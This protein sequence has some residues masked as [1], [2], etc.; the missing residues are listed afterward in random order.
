MS[1]ILFLFVV[2][3]VVISTSQVTAN[4]YEKE[5]RNSYDYQLSGLLAEYSLDEIKSMLG[6]NNGQLY[7]DFRVQSDTEGTVTYQVP[8]DDAELE[9][10]LG[11]SNNNVQNNDFQPMNTIISPDFTW[12]HTIIRDSGL[13]HSESIVI[14]LMG[15]AFT[16]ADYGTWP[17][18]AAGTVLALADAAISTMESTYPFSEFTHLFTVYVV[19]VASETSGTN[20]ALGTVTE[21]GNLVESNDANDTVN[22]NEIRRLAREI[23]ANADLTVL[24]VI[25]NATARTGFG[26][27]ALNDEID[28]NIGVTS[29][30]TATNGGASTHWPRAWHGTIIHEFGHTLGKL[31]DNHNT[32]GGRDNARANI[33]TNGNTNSVKWQHWLGHQN[34]ADVP[35]SIGVSDGTE[36]FVPSIYT[37]RGT[38]L[39]GGN[40]IMVASWAHGEFCGVCAEE[41][42]RRMGSNTG[43]MLGVNAI[44]FNVISRTNGISGFRTYTIR[45]ENNNPFAAEVT[46]IDRQ[47]SESTAR[48]FS[49]NNTVTIMIPANGSQNVSI[50]ESIGTSYIAANIVFVTGPTRFRMISYANELPAALSDNGRLNRKFNVQDQGVGFNAINLTA[51]TAEIT[52]STATLIGEIYIPNRINGRAVTSIGNSAFSGQTR[53][54]TVHLPIPLQTLGNSAFS[55][56]SNLNE[57]HIS[58]SVTTIGS[59]AFSNTNNAPIYL[60]GRS[61]VPSTFDRNWNSSENPVYLNGRLCTHNKKTIIQLDSTQHGHLC[62]DCR[63]ITNKE[64]HRKYTS[65]GW[66]YCYDCSYSKPH[67]HS[68]TPTWINYKLHELKCSCGNVTNLI[69]HVVS[70]GWNGIGYATCLE[71]GGPAEIGIVGPSYKIGKTNQLL[72]IFVLDYFGNGSFILNNGVI[73][74]SDKDLVHYY[75]GTLVIPV[76][77][78]HMDC[79]KHENL[80]IEIVNDNLYYDID[81]TK[82]GFILTSKKQ[83]EIY[84][85]K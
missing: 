62:N 7:R 60:V 26:W 27:S 36:W 69:G 4:A 51:T 8:V 30:R 42:S 48:Y 45:L 34:V 43:W 18:P 54:T 28:I 12:P 84:K 15:D 38:N 55:G 39:T 64:N 61:G 5:A 41:L 80:D 78:S 63:T 47:V 71:C 46:Y 82:Y 11:I 59:D 44:N 24:Q 20:G 58:S 76:V 25:A 85:Y 2:L 21:D 14:V 19:H 75:N 17:S 50:S 33:T 65:N 13:S 77:G 66:D 79:C 74:L 9:S 35:Q 57:I 68:Y 29:I 16:A 52:G 53:M 67:T 70:G 56:C 32:A 1:Q 22:R 3:T 81:K 49:A 31:V 6:A 83:I 40:C 73:V 72:E 37:M 23:V 10:I